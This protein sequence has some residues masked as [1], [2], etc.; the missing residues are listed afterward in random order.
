[1]LNCMP[2]KEPSGQ[3]PLAGARSW[4]SQ[5]AWTGVRANLHLPAL[6]KWKG[7]T[8][9]RAPAITSLAAIPS[10]GNLLLLTQTLSRSF[11]WQTGPRLRWTGEFEDPM[12]ITGLLLLIYCTKKIYIY[13][14]KFI[15]GVDYQNKWRSKRVWYHI[16][17]CD[18]VDCAWGWKV[19]AAWGFSYSA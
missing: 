17:R 9:F 2:I 16:S 5:K 4:G 3:P 18:N 19:S 8:F 15:S 14:C 1:M 10:T 7:T 12:S 13:N 11:Q 6:F